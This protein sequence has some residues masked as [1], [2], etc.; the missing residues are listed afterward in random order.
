METWK[1]YLPIL[2]WLISL[3]LVL[4]CL[5]VYP[6]WSGIIELL[7]G[8]LNWARCVIACPLTD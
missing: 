3:A 5:F 8:L 6:G 7:D 2:G 1:S 4:F